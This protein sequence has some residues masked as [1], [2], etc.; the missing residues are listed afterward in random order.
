MG[1]LHI[2]GFSASVGESS[3]RE[4]VDR[5]EEEALISAKGARCWTTSASC[6][7]FGL[8]VDSNSAQ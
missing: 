2:E 7:T 8:S 6:A 3:Q 4:D 1:Q 5:R